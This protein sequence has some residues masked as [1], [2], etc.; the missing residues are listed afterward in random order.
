MPSFANGKAIV[1]DVR[2]G[3][4]PV[5]GVHGRARWST[6]NRRT[7]LYACTGGWPARPASAPSPPRTAGP[8]QRTAGRPTAAPRAHRQ[9]GPGDESPVPAAHPAPP[10]RSHGRAGCRS[11][12]GRGGPSAHRPW[13]S[14]RRTSPASPPSQRPRSS[15]AALPGPPRQSPST[16]AGPQRAG[17]RPAPEADQRCRSCQ[18]HAESVRSSQRSP[19]PFGCSWPI[20]RDLPLGRTQA[21][22]RHLNFYEDRD[23]LRQQVDRDS[24]L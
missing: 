17:R 23:T 5:T 14:Q 4:G 21:G 22:D 1:E 11:G 10:S 20:T 9:C 7:C 2:R 24:L 19:F 3:G 12:P 13:R 18:P 6:A 8:R 15:P 16:R